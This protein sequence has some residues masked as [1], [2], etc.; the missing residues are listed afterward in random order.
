MTLQSHER[1]QC[2][3]IQSSICTSVCIIQKVFKGP[4]VYTG[5]RE[6]GPDHAKKFASQIAI[7]GKL[8]G[9]GEGKSKKSA[10]QAAALQTL[11]MLKKEDELGKS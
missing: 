7:A 6:S 1:V 3:V 5:V 10:E 4:P 2:C 8:Y 9:H 11:E